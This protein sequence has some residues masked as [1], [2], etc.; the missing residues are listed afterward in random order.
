M[1]TYRYSARNADGLLMKG[2]ERADSAAVLAAQ[3]QGGG[4]IPV[5]IEECAPA[6]AGGKKAAL[7]ARKV[8]REELIFF[9]TQMSALARAGLPLVR[10]LHGIAAGHRNPRFR[11]ALAAVIDDL[12]G[13]R[14]LAD[15]LARHPKV[16]PLLLTS[17]VQVGE[18]TGRLSESFHEVGRYLLQEKETTDQMKSALRYPAFVIIAMAAAL[19]VI[20]VFVIPAFHRIFQQAKVELPLPTRILLA[21]SDFAVNYWIWIVAG[22]AAAWLGVLRWRR[23]EKG[24]LAWDRMKLRL[25]LVGGILLRCVLVRFSRAF[26]MSYQ[27]GVPLVQALGLTALAVGNR[28]V[29]AGIEQL[30]NGVERGDTLAN[31][32]AAT[33]LFTPLVLQMIAV[34]EETGRID[35]MLREVADF[36]EREVAYDLKQ[37][38]ATIEPVLIVFMGVLV[39]ILALGV[40]LPMWNLYA[41]ARGRG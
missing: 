36:Y 4:L 1:P 22:L 14:S 21:T 32:A 37:L 16:F 27:A 6:E 3:L 28:F 17:M 12:E 33:G 25:P 20:N 11:E 31:S 26:A 9:C 24:A 13:G 23:T 41:V 5:E 15:S 2:E 10:T 7:F 35:V 34:G 40:F 19:A 29:G 38:T 8:S 39:L 18:N 30:R